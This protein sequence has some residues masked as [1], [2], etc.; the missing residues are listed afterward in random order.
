MIISISSITK[1]KYTA[2]L[3]NVFHKGHFYEHGFILIPAWTRNLIHKT[4][5]TAAPLKFVNGSV[6]SSNILLAGLNLINVIKRDPCAFY[7]PTS[8]WRDDDIPVVSLYRVFLGYTIHPKHYAHFSCSVVPCCGSLP[9]N[10]IHVFRGNW[11]AQGDIPWSHQYE[12]SNHKSVN[13]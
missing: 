8:L 6:I 4:T 5:S 2:I 9:V 10:I 1:L 13:E 7:D 12:R 3:R 11:L